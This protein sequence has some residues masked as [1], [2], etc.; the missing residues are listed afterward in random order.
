[1]YAVVTACHRSFRRRVALA[2]LEEIADAVPGQ[3]DLKVVVD[4]GEHPVQRVMGVG[5]GRGAQHPRPPTDRPRR[6]AV[7]HVVR[8]RDRG[9]VLVRPAR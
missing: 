3:L 7:R 5:L 9:A 4:R 8:V 6:Q 1:M 2:V